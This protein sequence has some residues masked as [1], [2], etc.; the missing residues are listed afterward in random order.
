MRPNAPIL[1]VDVDANQ[2]W[3]IEFWFQEE[4]YRT[5]SAAAGSWALE[6]WAQHSPALVI[7]EMHVPGRH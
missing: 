5:I 4:G 2:R 6:R 1:I 3:L 7:A